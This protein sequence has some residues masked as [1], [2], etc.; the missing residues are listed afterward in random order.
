MRAREKFSIYEEK[1]VARLKIF[2]AREA[3]N[4]SKLE[5]DNEKKLIWCCVNFFLMTFYIKKIKH[6]TFF[7]VDE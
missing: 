3:G 6:F 4:M 7:F 5:H 2:N 1:V